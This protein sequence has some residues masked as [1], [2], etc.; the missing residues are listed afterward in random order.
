[1]QNAYNSKPNNDNDYLIIITIFFHGARAPRGTETPHYRGFTITLR[2]TTF[3]RTPLD[4][5]SAR[6]GYLCLTTRSTH[7]RFP[8]LPAGFEAAI[9][10]SERP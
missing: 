4:V 7:K 2:H 9:P 8:F 1:M 3:G 10:A 5:L 6:R